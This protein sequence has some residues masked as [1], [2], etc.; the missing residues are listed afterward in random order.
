MTNTQNI[1][2]AVAVEGNSVFGKMVKAEK[3]RFI[4]SLVADNKEAVD[5]LETE[6]Q[7]VE[8]KNAKR[9]TK[10]SATQIE[11]DELRQQV[12]LF[13]EDKGEQVF[14]ADQLMEV[15]GKQEFSA[16]KATAL[17]KGLVDG[18]QLE[19]VPNVQVEVANGETTKKVRKMGYK[20]A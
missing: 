5:F 8:N 14:I 6:A 15:I 10:K 2:V 18:G 16:Q 4:A 17:L 3:L 13:M 12:M 7:R 11:N 19:K 9:T 20:L 1:Q